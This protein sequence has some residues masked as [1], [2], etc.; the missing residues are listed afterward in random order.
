MIVVV[1]SVL[2][3]LLI[4]PNFDKP[5]LGIIYGLFMKHSA[6]TP[7]V[8]QILIRYI[9]LTP[10]THNVWWNFPVKN[11]MWWNWPVLHVSGCI[12][13]TRVE[14]LDVFERPKLLGKKL[15]I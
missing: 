5:Q 10:L 15:T 6:R 1:V 14:E 4:W 8:Y 3:T 7:I 9:Y 11:N 13:Q 12:L 2:F